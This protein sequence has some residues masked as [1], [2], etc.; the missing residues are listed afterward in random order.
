MKIFK[1]QK[2]IIEKIKFLL[3]SLGFPFNIEYDVFKTSIIITGQFLREQCCT[4]YGELE[5]PIK[6]I[7]KGI[8]KFVGWQLEGNGRFLLS[9]FTTVHN[10]PKFWES[11]TKCIC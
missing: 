10:T 8:G 3:G 9:D 7:E 1:Y 4:V 2:N 6:I 5:S 11:N